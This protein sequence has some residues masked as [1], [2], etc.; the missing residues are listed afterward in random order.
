[1]VLRSWLS[2]W[3]CVFGVLPL[4]AAAHERSI[5]ECIEGS[6]FI[7]HAAMSR[8]N[9]HS[10]EKFMRQLYADLEAIQS[11]PAALRWFVQDYDDQALLVS[12]TEEVF[13]T[14]GEPTDHRGRFMNRCL[15]AT[16]SSR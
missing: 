5:Q 3:A 14:P 4:C 12:A 2:R 15:V 6:E 16:T 13:D 8:D 11:Y 10:R 9:G 7:E 1:M